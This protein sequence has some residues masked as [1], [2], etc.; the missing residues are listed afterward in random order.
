MSLFVPDA[1]NPSRELDLFDLANDLEAQ[2]VGLPLLLRFSDMLCSRIESLTE[3]SRARSA[4][5]STRAATRRS[6]RSR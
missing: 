2:G 5:T 6:I 3:A 1:D 4:S